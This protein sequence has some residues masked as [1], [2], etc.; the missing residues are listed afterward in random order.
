[1]EVLAMLSRQEKELERRAVFENDRLVRE[2]QKQQQ[3]QASTFHQH[4]VAQAD[5]INQGRFAATGVPNVIGAKPSVAAAYPAASPSWQIQLP[6]EP[7]LGFDNP[8]FEPSTPP[9]SV[10]QLGGDAMTDAPSADPVTSA[11][12]SMF[13]RS[14]SPPSFSPAERT[15]E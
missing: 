10:E 9:A 4:A 8:A 5:E 14:A 7:P 11:G 12:S 13:E 1:M 6:D 2:Q 3:Q 15:D